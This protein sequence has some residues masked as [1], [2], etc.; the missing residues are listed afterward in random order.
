M[1]LDSYPPEIL[2][3]DS[4]ND[5]HFAD[6]L[7]NLNFT[8]YRTEIGGSCRG[9]L[10]LIDRSKYF[11][12]WNPSTG[13]HKQIPASPIII[14]YHDNYAVGKTLS[15]FTYNPSTDDYLVVLGTYRYDRDIRPVSDSI[16]LEVFSL[17]ANNWKQIEIGSR[18][19]YAA[20]ISSLGEI[21][22]GLFFNGSIHWLVKNYDTNKNVVIALDLKEMR[23][24]EITLPD[25][26]ANNLALDCGLLV[27]RGHISA[28]IVE[29][30]TIE[31]WVMQEH[32]SWTKTLTFSFH[33]VLDFAPLCF[34]NSGDI[35]GISLD[36]GLVKFDVKGEQLEYRSFHD[37]YILKLQIV[38]YTES[39]LSFPG[40]TEQ[41]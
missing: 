22:V 15:A 37:R 1:L 11:Y 33:P 12:L 39:L 34:T 9:L 38:V 31:I 23:M 3:I 5:H 7:I 30:Q 25:Y 6:A 36:S 16:E 4:D 24:S 29:M 20:S 2:S 35:V 26:F 10:F 14:T 21:T 8:S 27:F 32:S 13:I 40:G 28:W 17:R 19:P 18:L 41:A